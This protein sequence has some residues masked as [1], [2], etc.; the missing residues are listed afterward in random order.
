MYVGVIFTDGTKKVFRAETRYKAKI[1]AGFASVTLALH[2]ERD[3]F[4]SVPG[5]KTVAALVRAK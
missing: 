2:N 1:Y 5:R 4:A 3:W